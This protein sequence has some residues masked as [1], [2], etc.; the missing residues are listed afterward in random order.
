M[1]EKRKKKKTEWLSLLDGTGYELRVRY[2]PAG[3][4]LEVN[5]CRPG[6]ISGYTLDRGAVSTGGE[7]YNENRAEWWDKVVREKPS[8][9]AGEEGL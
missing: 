3:Q 4:R 6:P 1:N 2:R 7:S 9:Q 5:L 8:E